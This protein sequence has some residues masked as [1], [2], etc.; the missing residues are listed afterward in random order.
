MA[1]KLEEFRRDVNGRFY[2][3]A[4]FQEYYKTTREWD[5][6]IG[7]RVMRK[8]VESA[9]DACADRNRD[10]KRKKRRRKKQSNGRAA[11]RF[12]DRCNYVCA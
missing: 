3:K 2:S 4:Q 11:A 10:K 1:S 7:S 9:N 12:V 8:S 5:A 6:A